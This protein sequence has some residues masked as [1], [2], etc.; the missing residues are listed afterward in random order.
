VEKELHAY[1]YIHWTGGWVGHRI[2]LDVV[3]K[4][5]FPASARNQTPF[6]QHIA[7]HCIELYQPY[8]PL[9]LFK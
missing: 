8:S 6:L 7:T 4:G 5:K 9:V 3:A 1:P 2:G